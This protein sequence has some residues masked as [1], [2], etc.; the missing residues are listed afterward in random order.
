MKSQGFLEKHRAKIMP[1]ERGDCWLWSG[2]LRN[3]YGAV[4]AGGKTH[5]AHR[6]AFEDAFGLGSADGLVVRHR[7]DVRACVNPSH[8]ELGTQADNVRDMIERGRSRY[9]PP[10]GEAHG[11]AKLTNAEVREIRGVY[12]PGDPVLGA[13]GL[14]RKYGVHNSLISLIVRNKLWIEAL[15]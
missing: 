7:C 9:A 8:L 3:G 2:A 12:V 11:C 14:A 4:R 1:G 6:R 10:K 15:R 13:R 5:Y